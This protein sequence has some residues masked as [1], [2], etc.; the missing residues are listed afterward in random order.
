M[1]EVAEQTFK[2][3]CF[4]RVLM[5]L[6]AKCQDRERRAKFLAQFV[7]GKSNPFGFSKSGRCSYDGAC[8]PIIDP[9]FEVV[10]EAA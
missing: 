4:G 2:K 10:T 7:N 3:P 5:V 8:S 9:I 1:T 6:T